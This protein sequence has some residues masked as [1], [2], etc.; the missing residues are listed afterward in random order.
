MKL[1]K[2]NIV[3]LIKQ[4]RQQQITQLSFSELR[5]AQNKSAAKKFMPLINFLVY[6]PWY[7]AKKYKK[8]TAFLVWVFSQSLYLVFKIKNFVIVKL[9]WGRGK[10]TKPILHI[11][12]LLFICIVFLTGDVFQKDLIVLSSEEQELFVSSESDIVPQTVVLKT[13]VG[14]KLR[15]TVTIYTVK[16]GDTLSTIG[17]RFG[18]TTGT[19]RYANNMGQSD[20]LMVGQKLSIPPVSGVVYK[21]AKGDT[22][23]TIASKFAVSEQ[24][25]AD[26][27]YLAAP[28][29][30]SEGQE[31]ILPDA[32]I[33]QPIFAYN[34]QPGINPPGGYDT[35]AYGFIPQAVSGKQ[36]SGQFVW[37]TPSR[38][39]SQYFSWYHPAIDIAIPGPIFAA[40]AGVVV[41]SGWWAGGYGFAIQIDHRNGFVTTYAHMSRLDVSVNDSVDRGQIIGLMGSTGRSTGPHLHFTIQKN[42]QYLNPLEFY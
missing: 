42:G 14:S 5:I 4:L 21:V 31:L 32:K 12:T 13:S 25:V 7:F 35:S 9:I 16:P 40:D 30:L 20:F 11:G 18:V 36:G 37:P 39:I 41:R 19:I 27:N 24:A 1:P 33:P 34:S 6:I 2:F 23:K 22:I 26:F 38:Y 15:D 28:F 10:L 29:T 17:R 3:N 8:F